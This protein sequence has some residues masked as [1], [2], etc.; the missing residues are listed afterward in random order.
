ML[1]KN[2]METNV[3]TLKKE[4]PV[5]DIAALMIQHGI[6]GFPVVDEKGFVV[7]VVS[8]FDLMR[9]E[10][11]PEDPNLWTVCIWGIKNN[12]HLQEYIDSAR[13][14][15][16]ET[17]GDIMT[18]PAVT[19]D[20]MDDIETVGNLMFEEKIKRVFVTKDRKLVGVISRSEFVKLLLRH[21]SE[22]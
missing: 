2:V 16:A 15:L 22:I 17:A 1:A 19:V 11:R 10:I 6:S 12:K 9:K 4:T 13:K 7:G 5:K 3:I 18:T 8:E 14:Y 21:S 20:E